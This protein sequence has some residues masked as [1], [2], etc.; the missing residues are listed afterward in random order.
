MI[1]SVK[2]GKEYY[3]NF[4]KEEENSSTSYPLTYTKLFHNTLSFWNMLIKQDFYR[5]H[6]IE[7]FLSCLFNFTLSVTIFRTEEY[8]IFLYSFGFSVSAHQAVTKL[9]IQS[10]LNFKSSQ[11]FELS[12]VQGNFLCPAICVHIFA[13]LCSSYSTGSCYFHRKFMDFL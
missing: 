4:Q 1:Q 7:L 9:C 12:I 5:I 2:I 3:F 13:I 10:C 11:F 6:Y 8:K